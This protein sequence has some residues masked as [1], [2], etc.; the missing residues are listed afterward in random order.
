M[1]LSGLFHRTKTDQLYG[2]WKLNVN[3]WVKISQL[4]LGGQ[5]WT[6]YVV[7]KYQRLI[8]ENGSSSEEVVI[9]CNHGSYMLAMFPPKKEETHKY[10][11]ICLWSHTSAI[12]ELCWIFVWSVRCPGNV[13][14]TAVCMIEVGWV[15]WRSGGLCVP[16][17]WSPAHSYCSDSSVI[18]TTPGCTCSSRSAQDSLL[19]M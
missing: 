3:K 8:E 12:P 9:T 17:C 1:T 4:W 2:K 7:K 5:S 11:N 16:L 19:E 10:Y 13:L 6:T 14:Y 15:L 18:P